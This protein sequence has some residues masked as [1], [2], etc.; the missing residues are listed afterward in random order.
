[1]LRREASAARRQQANILGSLREGLFLIGRD[2][3]LRAPCSSALSELLHLP[4][5]C[6]QRFEQLLRPLLDDEETLAAA[7][8]FLQLL[9]N[10]RADED[11][12]ESLNPL[13]QV[14]VSFAD[15][16]GGCERGAI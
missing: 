9:W 11:A 16:H 5:P 13:S 4:T 1:M 2:L 8:T 12:V 3:R 10:D 6:G 15:S 7:L 14:Q